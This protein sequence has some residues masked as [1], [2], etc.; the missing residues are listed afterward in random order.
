MK[1][2][3]VLKHTIDL[4]TNCEKGD[5][6]IKKELFLKGKHNYNY[7]CLLKILITQIKIF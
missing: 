7:D 6:T 1:K 2:V 5:F 4:Y 3:L